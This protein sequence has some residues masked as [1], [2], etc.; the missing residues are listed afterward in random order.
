MENGR[1]AMMKIKN[2]GKYLFILLAISFIVISSC[3]SRKTDIK[4]RELSKIS[5]VDSVYSAMKSAEFQFETMIAKFSG[6]YNIDGNKQNFSGQIRL[7]KDSLIWCSITVMNIEVA[8]VMITTDTVKMMNRLSKEYFVSDFEL[9]NSKLNTDI[10]FDML[11]ALI[12]GNDIPYYEIDKF[13]LEVRQE[14]FVLSTIGRNKLKNYIKSEDDL[15]KILIQKMKIDRENFRITSQ[16]IKQLRNP[17]KKVEAT[18]SNFE[19]NNGLF[20]T[21]MEF[22]FIGVKEIFVSFDFSRIEKNRELSFPFK[23]PSSYSIQQGN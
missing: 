23:V 1:E 17:N 2:G 13:Q 9:L 18:Y 3:K 7:F 15:S 10:D 22:K 20:P 16:D 6:L 4:P 14:V 8:R 19:D 11:Q 21:T 5:Q 12:L